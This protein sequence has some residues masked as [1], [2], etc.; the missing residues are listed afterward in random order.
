M[1]DNLISCYQV[2]ETMLDKNLLSNITNSETFWRKLLDYADNRDFVLVDE[3]TFDYNHYFN[4]YIQV[5][6]N[7]NSN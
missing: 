7:E 5:G 2:A 4:N 6:N 3:E 1:N